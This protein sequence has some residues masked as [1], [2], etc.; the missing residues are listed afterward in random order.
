MPVFERVQHFPRPIAEVFDCFCNTAHIVTVAPP[1]LH[2]RLDEGPPTLHL[3]ARLAVTASRLGMDQ[4]LVTEI[5]A[6][7][8]NALIVEEQREGLLARW[9][10]TR[11]F[12]PLG[13]GTQVTEQVE[14]EPPTGIMGWMVTASLIDQEL[15][16]LFEYRQKK[17]Q[18]LLG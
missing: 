9:V 5:T 14:Y 16:A 4:R 13:D 3:G 18:E 8:P 15:T 2:L 6:F 12:A 10:H 11:R 1:A 17:W 7:E